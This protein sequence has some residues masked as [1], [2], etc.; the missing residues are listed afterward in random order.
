M[1][2]HSAAQSSDSA[3][4]MA[5]KTWWQTRV[6]ELSAELA[7]FGSRLHALVPSDMG[8]RHL[9]NA[10]VLTRVAADMARVQQVSETVAWLELLIP[11]GHRHDLDGAVRGLRSSLTTAEDPALWSWN[12]QGWE[13]L[14]SALWRRDRARTVGPG[15]ADHELVSRWGV[16]SVEASDFHHPGR[17]PEEHGYSLTSLTGYL[18]SETEP[19]SL[20][21]QAVLS[22]ADVVDSIEDSLAVYEE[23]LQDAGHLAFLAEQQLCAEHLNAWCDEHA[24][25]ASDATE[26]FLAELSESVESYDTRV[27]HPVTETLSRCENALLHAAT[28]P[29]R[30]AQHAYLAEFLACVDTPPAS[31]WADDELDDWI[32]QEAR[33]REARGEFTWHGMRGSVP[34]WYHIVNSPQERAAAL[35]LSGAATSSAIRIDADIVVARQVSLFDEL[36]WSKEPAEPE[37]WYPEPGIALRYSRHSAVD[38]CELLALAALRH[39]RLEFL[40]QG[41]DGRLVLLRSLRVDVRPGDAE[42]WAQGALTHLWKLVPNVDDLAEVIAGEDEEDADPDDADE[43]GEP[44]SPRPSFD[45]RDSAHRR[46][47]Q[48][49]TTTTNGAA[50]PGSTGSDGP[51]VPPSRTGDPLPEQLLARVKAI[52]RQAEDPAATPAESETFMKKAA[53]LMAKYG[54]EQAMLRGD[55]PTSEQPTDRVVEVTAPWMSECKRLLAAIAMQMRCQAIYPGGKSN[56]HRVHLFGFASD[57]HAVEVLYTSLRLQMLRGAEAADSRHRPAGEAARA[58]KRSW[59]LGFIRAVTARIGEAERAARADTE[60]E[61]RQ[62]DAADVAQGRSV[63]LVLADR[64]AAV[65]AEVTSHYPK[66]KAARR[67]RFTGSGFRQG[68]LDGQRADIGGPSLEAED[69]EELIA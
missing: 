43:W 29:Q 21:A 39:A 64:N 25:G 51:R 44:D 28:S 54:I 33:D 66:V 32:V 27:V 65:Q 3:F 53:S 26:A 16:R 63:A 14:V 38:L 7:V 40:I 5:R 68:H 18:E 6:T 37:D 20:L 35:A 45:D 10:L 17:A 69:E 60:R 55:E 9:V 41:A 24:R 48:A 62:G 8:D 30:R 52:L 4:V 50:G 42:A 2:E 59:M 31:T 36:D 46:Q 13:E 49:G 47:D 56:R 15:Q 57:L 22:E 67:T 58:Y 11:N 1:A 61:R 34:T 12:A 19:L 23:V